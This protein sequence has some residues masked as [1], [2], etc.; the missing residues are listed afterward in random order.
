MRTGFSR[1]PGHTD[2]DITHMKIL[3]NNKQLLYKAKHF[4]LFV[5]FEILENGKQGSEGYPLSSNFRASNR[6]EPIIS[7]EAFPFVSI[8]VVKGCLLA[9]SSSFKI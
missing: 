3:L 5:C 4:F 9:A 7:N 2:S 6:T 1:K 8:S